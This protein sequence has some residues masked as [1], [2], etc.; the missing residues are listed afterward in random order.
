MSDSTSNPRQLIAEQNDRFRR[1]CGLP[2][3][4]AARGV[5]GQTVMTAG[6]AAL[7]PEK[8]GEII[9]AVMAFD[10]F[11]EANDPYGEHDFGRIDIDGV[12]PIFWKFDYYDQDLVYGSENPSDLTRTMRVLTIMLAGEY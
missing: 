4:R 5:P 1:T 11:T 3:S 10:H 8:Q 6:I 12:G 2:L 9:E 7:P